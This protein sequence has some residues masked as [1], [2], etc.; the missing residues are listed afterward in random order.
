M[1]AHEC[2]SGEPCESL[3]QCLTQSGVSSVGEAR[4]I[5][6]QLV[7]EI[8]IQEV[9]DGDIDT[10]TQGESGRFEID[11][12]DKLDWAVRKVNQIDDFANKRIECAER[13]ILRLQEYIRRVKE[14]TEKN[15]A[16]LIEMMKP[17]VTKLLVGS[18][19]RS[20]ATPSGTVGFRAQQP[21]FERND[22][23]LVEWLKSNDRSDYV[24]VKESPKW[25]EL[26][27]QVAKVLDDGSCVLSDGEL[28]P[29]EALKAT[30]RPD[31]LYVKPL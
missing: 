31:V 18:K 19:K 27:K 12:L 11:S 25:A 24:Q 28:I 9:L 3:A 5:N 7:P 23:V 8:E 29:A 13:Q 16:G 20:F 17:F 2:M 30:P 1:C 26:K 15:K 6:A 14:E 4:R 10:E 22:E 21:E